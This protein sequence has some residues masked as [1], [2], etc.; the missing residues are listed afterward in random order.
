M[1]SLFVLRIFYA[2]KEETA[3]QNLLIGTE[4]LT[5]H[6]RLGK[7]NDILS[8]ETTICRFLC[9]FCEFGI[10]IDGRNAAFIDSFCFDAVGRGDALRAPCQLFLNCVSNGF[11]KG[12]NRADHFYRVGN[13]VVS[14]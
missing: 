2:N 14:A 9:I 11:V 6:V 12:S 10:I 13:D 1:Q 8:T 5:D 3:R 4:V 7:F